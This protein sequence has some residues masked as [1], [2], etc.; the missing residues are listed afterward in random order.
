MPLDPALRVYFD[1]CC[2]APA[3]VSDVRGFM[4]AAQAGF[5]RHLPVLAAKKKM[6]IAWNGEHV[7]QRSCAADMKRLHGICERS[8]F[9]PSRSTAAFL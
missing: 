4:A 7:E 6:T 1:C 5:D 9:R 3:G 2:G 8:H